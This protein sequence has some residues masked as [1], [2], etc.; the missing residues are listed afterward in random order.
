M[1]RARQ[2]EIID[3]DNQNPNYPR[4]YNHAFTSRLV[5]LLKIGCVQHVPNH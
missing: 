1:G 3:Y 5:R 2:T 4:E